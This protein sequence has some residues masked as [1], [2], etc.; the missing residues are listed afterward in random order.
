MPFLC[1]N[2][3]I[4]VPRP[5]TPTLPAT[6][7]IPHLTLHIRIRPIRR[8]VRSR[9]ISRGTLPGRDSL[10]L[11]TL[12]SR[13]LAMRYSRLLFLLLFSLSNIGLLAQDNPEGP[14]SEKAQKTYKEALE[15]VH[16]HMIDFALDNFKK[17]D[18]QDEG[19]CI[20]CQ[21]KM[22]KYGLELHDWKAAQTAADEMVAEAQGDKNIALAHFEAGIILFDEGVDR[23]KDELFS[24]AHDEFTKALAAAPNFPDA[25]ISDGK[26]LAHLKQDDAAKAQ[27]EKYVKM[28]PD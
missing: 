11:E 7:P 28:K 15:D 27:F 17:A 24:H 2:M 20:A 23:H 8:I 16:K 4:P 25:I 12:N 14:T 9:L 6:T 18:K 19:R 3:G 10:P 5:D 13:R 26:A 22:I 1:A 21:R